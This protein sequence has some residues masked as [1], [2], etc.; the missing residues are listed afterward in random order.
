MTN[1]PAKSTYQNKPNLIITNASD[2]FKNFHTVRAVR[3]TS[4]YNKYV[5][6][7]VLVKLVKHFCLILLG[8]LCSLHIPTWSLLNRML[9][10]LSIAELMLMFLCNYLFCLHLQ[11][12]RLCN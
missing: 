10:V 8:T 9:G 4:V 6:T 2:S 1:S 7:Y 11:K 5:Y 3:N 12:S